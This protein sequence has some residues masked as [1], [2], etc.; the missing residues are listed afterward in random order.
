MAM[1]EALRNGAIFARQLANE[2]ADEAKRDDK[3]AAYLMAEHDRHLRRAEFY[4]RHIAKPIN[5]EIA[6]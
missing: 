3:R 6:E 1:N 4:E 5:Q 2:C